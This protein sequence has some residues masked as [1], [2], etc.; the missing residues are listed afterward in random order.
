MDVLSDILA[1]LGLEGSLY[2][3][4][5]FNPPWGV[6]VPSYK[7]VIRFHFV[8]RGECW[9][10]VGE[11]RRP[12]RLA[13]GDFILIPHGAQHALLD[14]ATREALQLDDVLARSG[15]SGTGCFVYGGTPTDR[16]TRM[17]CGHLAFDANARH[18]LLDTL[19]DHL[20]V[21]A[22]EKMSGS[23]FDLTLRFLAHEADAGADRIG[24]TAVIKRLTEIIFIQVMNTWLERERPEQGL[25]A[26][27]ADRRL[28]Q[29]LRA[30]HRN[31]SQSWTVASLARE[32]G[33]S[34]TVFAERF[35]KLSG[36]SP[37]HYLTQWRLEKAR[38]LLV[39]SPHS[40]AAIAD[41]VGYQ[42]LAAFNR[43]FKKHTTLSPGAYKRHRSSTHLETA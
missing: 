1:H 18:P 27:L 6:Q 28:G 38:C 40:V 11:A 33:M 17:I 14:M 21:R 29:S 16:Q 26:A 35:K 24:T 39:E 3:T 41:S 13:P 2:F 19:P 34:R 31:P 15:Y 10:R 25:L 9:V 12:V 5:E 7:N 37:L 32:A 22:T 20:V 30:I 4:T 42:S 36:L 43:A 8:V 23:W